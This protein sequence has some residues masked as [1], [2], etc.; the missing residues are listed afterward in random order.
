MAELEAITEVQADPRK[1]TVQGRQYGRRFPLAAGKPINLGRD[2]AKMDIAIPEDDQISRFQA[3]LTWEPGRE[4]L[5]VQTRPVTPPNYPTPPANQT[6]VFDEKQKKLVEAPGGRCV[7]GKGE[8]FW[9]GQTRFTLHSDGEQEPESPAD[10]TIAPRQ[11]ERTR[12]Q[13]EEIPFANPGAA[14]RAME[15]LPAMIRAVKCGESWASLKKRFGCGN[16]HLGTQKIYDATLLEAAAKAQRQHLVDAYRCVVTHALAS[17]PRPSRGEIRTRLV[18]EMSYLEHHDK[19]WLRLQL[20][21]VPRR[22]R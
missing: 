11:E 8:S 10:M 15:Q 13:L 9:I 7:V 4:K 20:D 1:S 5:T 12:A 2:E 14:L 6:L 18:T 19:A 22:N 3:I 21:Q 16:H 17:N